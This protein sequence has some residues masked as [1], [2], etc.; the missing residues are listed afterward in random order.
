MKPTT[1]LFFFIFL[2][3]DSFSQERNIYLS[4]EAG[5]GYSFSNIID[6]GEDIYGNFKKKQD[7]SNRF[8]INVRYEFSEKFSVI[9]GVLLNGHNHG[10]EYSPANEE[11]SMS[12]LKFQTHIYI[13]I[14]FQNNFR[15]SSKRPL[16]GS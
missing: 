15:I 10:V 1:L 3:F 13:P 2:F 6:V 4:I 16:F 7:I 11:L 12:L 8:G 9:A 5:L 14:R